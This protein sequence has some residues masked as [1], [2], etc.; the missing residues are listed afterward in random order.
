MM[1]GSGGR[2]FFMTGFLGG[3]TTFSTFALESATSFQDGA[4]GV[5]LI[6]VLSN[7]AGGLVLVALGIWL[8]R[9]AW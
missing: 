6:N 2:L 1:L 7:T 9:L 3:L 8:G 4:F 5:S